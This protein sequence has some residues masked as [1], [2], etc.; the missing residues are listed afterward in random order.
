MISLRTETVSHHPR[1]SIGVPV[2]NGEKYLAAA[3]DSIL[4]QTFTDFEV[5]VS[6]NASTDRTEQICRE[7]AARDNRIRYVRQPKN[8]GMTWNFSH[9]VDLARGEYFRWHAHDDSCAPTLLDRCVEALDANPEAVLAYP[10]VQMIDDRGEPLPDDLS[11]WRPPQQTE[12]NGMIDDRDPRDLDSPAA[13]RRY[14]GVLMKTIWCLEPYG[15]MRTAVMHTTGKLRKLSRRGKGIHRRNGA[16]RAVDRSAGNAAARAAARR[17]VLDGRHG[18]R[19]AKLC[20]AWRSRQAASR[21]KLRL[22]IPRHVR[23][24]WGFLLLIPAAP[25][26]F[27]QRIRCLGVLTRYVLQVSKWKR[28]VVNTLRGTRHDRRLQ[29]RA[30]TQTASRCQRFARMPINC[31]IHRWSITNQPPATRPPQIPLDASQQ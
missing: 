22:P 25:I 28:I 3:L 26:S 10:R 6:D 19:S 2:Y 21:F 5:I 1:V 20:D 13:W 4:A 17:S 9:T 24:T 12:Q 29:A 31:R 30:P 27:V 18:Q 16:A 15:L 8:R 7:Y 23:S 11:T 14:Y